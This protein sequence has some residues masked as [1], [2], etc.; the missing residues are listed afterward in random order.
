MKPGSGEVAATPF[1][2]GA[3]KRNREESLEREP[4][5][6]RACILA[7]AETD[8]DERTPPHIAY[9]YLLHFCNVPA[10]RTVAVLAE[11]TSTVE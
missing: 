1:G 5:E 2:T 10:T 7:D 8:D 4:A 3:A 11:C 6:R 9:S